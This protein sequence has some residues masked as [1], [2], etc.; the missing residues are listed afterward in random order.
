MRQ[1]L[2]FDFFQDMNR[3]HLLEEENQPEDHEMTPFPSETP[4]AMAYV[5]FQQW[6][7]T[8][9]EEEGFQ[10]G[11]IFPQLHKP[12]CPGGEPHA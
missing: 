3:F 4:P 2:P 5:P 7:T 6:E 8:Y 9:T 12:F 1:D 10:Y 11:T